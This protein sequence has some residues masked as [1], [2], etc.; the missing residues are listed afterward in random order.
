MPLQRVKDLS[1]FHDF[2]LLTGSAYLDFEGVII[3][4]IGSN[5]DKGI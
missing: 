4:V 2:I 5:V 1:T 3:R